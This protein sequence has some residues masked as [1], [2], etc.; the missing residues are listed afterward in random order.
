MLLVPF[1]MQEKLFEN[2]L[3]FEK[4]SSPHTINAYLSDIDQFSQ[5]LHLVYGITE[6]SE[7]SHQHIRSWV[8]QLIEQ[9][10]AASSVNRKIS[11]LKALFRYLKKLGHVS[12]NPLSKVISPKRSLRLPQFVDEA[13]METL[14]DQKL[15]T[16]DFPGVRDKVIIE[17]FYNTGI[18]LTELINLKENQVDL[19]GETVK[20]LGKRNKER[21]IPV[22]CQF[23]AILRD[24]LSLK[25]QQDFPNQSEFLIVS[26]SGQK[27]YEKLVYRIVNR[28]LGMVT[29]INKKS[30]HILRHTFAT[31]M[32]NRGAE[33]NSIKEILGH[34]SLA[35]TQVYTH[36]SIEKLKDV[37]KKAHPKG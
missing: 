14:F 22:S 28:Y 1:F 23:A 13:G 35:A 30:P 29:T 20:V 19:A 12:V 27:V 4:R 32:L 36:N 37:H 17:L 18:R 9:D 33:L 5:Y 26:N 11:S 25:K 34:S 8:V 10:H 15:F 6:L 21:I 31:H 3:R 7:V 24:Y 2:Y 16:E